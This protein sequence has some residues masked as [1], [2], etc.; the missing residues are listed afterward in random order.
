MLP[1]RIRRNSRARI[2]LSAKELR[3]VTERVKDFEAI[4]RDR[5]AYHIHRRG[6][7]SWFLDE[8]YRKIA[9]FCRDNASVLDLGCGEGRMVDYI[10]VKYIDGVDYSSTG[11]ELNRKI[12]G[13]RYRK[14]AQGDLKDLGSLGFA[15]AS[16]ENVVCSLTLHCLD[17]QD[18]SL[19]LSA[20]REL[21][22]EDG[23]FIATY[24]NRA[25]LK[26]PISPLLAMSVDDLRSAF[27][28]AKFTIRQLVPICPF[29]SAEVVKESQ[30]DELSER[31]KQAFV[32][33]KSQ[34]TIENCYH[35]LL[36][37]NKSL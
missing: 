36:A 28:D 25:A 33:A 19:C 6:F 20:V 18:L 32:V 3:K 7:D 15:K 37:A 31:A 5:G 17:K 10:N 4:Y 2:Q 1:A 26:P 27:E 30:L 16:Y 14:L 29:V 9:E 34:M 12:Y 24:P 8:N 23:T 22:T 13:G 21:M 35:F 11:L